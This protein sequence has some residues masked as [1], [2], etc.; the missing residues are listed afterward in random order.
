MATLADVQAALTQLNTDFTSLENTPLDVVNAM[1]PK[2]TADLQGIQADLAGLAAVNAAALQAVKND[3]TALQGLPRRRGG[4][5][6]V[7]QL[8]TQLASDIAAL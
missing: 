1:L 4:D 3:L 8:V 5:S 2:I 7:T 6:A